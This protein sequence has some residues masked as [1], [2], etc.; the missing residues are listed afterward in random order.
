[1]NIANGNIVI[2]KRMKGETNDSPAIRRAIDAVRET[3]GTVYFCDSKY[4]ISEPIIIYRDVCYVGRGAGQT[5]I[6][7]E[8]GA[9]CDAFKTYNFDMYVN[10]ALY[11]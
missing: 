6:Y 8:I 3:G 9:N 11:G 4:Y 5:T 7:V 2:P 10:Q 1:M